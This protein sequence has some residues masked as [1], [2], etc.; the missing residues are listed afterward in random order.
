MMRK[1]VQKPVKAHHIDQKANQL[2]LQAMPMVITMVQEPVLLH[3]HQV[4]I[5]QVN[6]LL[7]QAITP[8]SQHVIA[9]RNVRMTFKI[10]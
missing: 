8:V 5:T 1:K 10:L 3:V 2:R 7:Q 4:I 6:L 9:S